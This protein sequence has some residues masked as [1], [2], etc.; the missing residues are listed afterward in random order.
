MLAFN[1]NTQQEEEVTWASDATGELICTFPTGHFLKFPKGITKEQVAYLLEEHKLH[2]QGKEIITPEMEAANQAAL[3]VT[4]D[5]AQELN[6]NTMPEGSQ[7][8]APP[9]PEVQAQPQA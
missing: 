7:N 8:N 2:N 3:K 1:A 6:G 5:I 9:A 4:Q